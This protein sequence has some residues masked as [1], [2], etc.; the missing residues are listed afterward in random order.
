MH[1]L[2]A[3]MTHDLQSYLE[4]HHRDLLGHLIP[5]GK[6]ALFQLHAFPQI[7]NVDVSLDQCVV[8]SCF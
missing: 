8:K 5:W 7:S 3:H 6:P 1:M 4:A 2:L